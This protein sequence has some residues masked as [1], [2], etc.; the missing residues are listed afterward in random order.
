MF[1]VLVGDAKKDF[2]E[3]VTPIAS[4]KVKATQRGLKRK[5]ELYYRF[6]DLSLL[7]CNKTYTIFPLALKF[8]L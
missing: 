8:H 6:L 5:M 1:Q 2:M 4:E 3:S 7:D